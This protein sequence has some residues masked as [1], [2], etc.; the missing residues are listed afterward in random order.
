MERR[1]VLALLL[2]SV[3]ASGLMV[4]PSTATAASQGEFFVHLPN[5]DG[6][7]STDELIEHAEDTQPPLVEEIES[8]GGEVVRR[9]WLTNALVVTG[10]EGL[11]GSLD[12]REDLRVHDNYEF[13]AP[14]TTPGR[15]G[16]AGSESETTE[17]EAKSGVEQVNATAV[18]EG[19]GVRG[20]GVSVAVLDTGVAVS[21]PDIRLETED[22]SD[23]RYPGG[24]AE[25]DGSGER[26]NSTPHDGARHGTH[27]SGT[28]VGGNA[29]GTW[30]GV[31]P[32]A[33]LTHAKVFDNGTGSF[34]SVLAGMEWSVS[35]N[36][37]VISL[38]FG[39][40]CEEESAYTSSMVEAVRN[41]R[42]AGS[43][44]VAPAGN[45]GD[46]CAASPGSVY[47]TLSVGAVDADGNVPS[48]SGGASVETADAW[49]EKAPS[50]WPASY[51]V[52]GVTAPGV[53]VLSAVPGGGH[54]RMDGTSMATPHV[55]GVAALLESSTARDL[56][57][58]EQRALILETARKTGGGNGVDTRKGAGVVDA[59]RAV[60]AARDGVNVSDS[61]PV[62]TT[63][64]DSA[65][66]DGNRT[67]GSP[68]SPLPG[69]GFLTGV[70]AVL[71]L[72]IA[73]KGIF[74]RRQI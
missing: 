72:I 59:Y 11:R 25:F 33:E 31:A 57:P 38:S 55:A 51:V 24:W 2:V 4:L 34:A 7:D 10:D 32:E 67:Q 69:F 30:I 6:A 20:E 12:E 40:P 70:V 19:F 74:R 16:E 41:A 52:P 71:L 22:A 9:F 43:L 27:V 53:G 26:V 13:G 66:T 46:G 15:A 50:G 36:A 29:S 68:S 37:D 3:C 42:D 61:L 62:N 21:H 14:T 54:E 60:S 17:F 47:D 63:E 64:T 28:V 8:E 49:S 45:G 5:D 73:R 56:T 44:V 58:E 35:Q 23:P 39:V 65:V 48:F 18:W 1:G